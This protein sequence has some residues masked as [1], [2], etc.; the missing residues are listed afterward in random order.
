MSKFYVYLYFSKSGLPL[1]VGKGKGKRWKHSNKDK[2]GRSRID[3]IL[4]KTDGGLPCAILQSG[5]TE[6]Q[7]FEYEKQFILAIGRVNAGTGPLVNL[8][9][10]GDGPSGMKHSKENLKLFSALKKGKPISEEHKAKLRAVALKSGCKPPPKKKGE[11][12]NE[13]A[14]R[15]LRE[16]MKARWADPVKREAFRQSLLGRKW[17]VGAPKT[18]P[19]LK[20]GGRL[21]AA[22]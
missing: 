6:K 21:A 11:S 10:G 4:L 22:D 2:T 1:Y 15:K 13:E 5:L 19:E 8:S 16:K 17:K 3:N 12:L 14:K 20:R 18:H 7:A 9:D